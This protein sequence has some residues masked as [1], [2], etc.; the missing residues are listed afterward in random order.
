MNTAVPQYHEK[1]ITLS[2][3]DYAFREFIGG[4]DVVDV[5]ETIRIML[6]DYFYGELIA[7]PNASHTEQD[8]TIVFPLGMGITLEGPELA[9]AIEML[10]EIFWSIADTISHRVL[11][12]TQEYSHRPNECFYKFFPLT[13]E[14]V[15]YTPVLEG[16]PLNP[17]FIALD[18]RA[19]MAACADTLPSWLRV[20]TPQ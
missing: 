20:T 9:N 7:V 11:M 10:G 17:A 19:V 1:R 5:G 16:L 8:R 12:V 13:R 18:G 15:V 3:I 14:L 6:A 2:E 4:P